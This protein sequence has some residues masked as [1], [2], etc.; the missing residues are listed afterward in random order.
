MM[1]QCKGGRQEL[2]PACRAG[3][4]TAGSLGPKQRSYSLE[5]YHQVPLGKRDLLK[6]NRRAAR[7]E[8][9]LMVWHG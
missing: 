1:Y 9:W 3:P 8:C 2:G 5:D 4:R 7:A 6:Q